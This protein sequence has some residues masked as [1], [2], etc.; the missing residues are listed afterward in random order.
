MWSL[1]KHA[2][3]TYTRTHTHWTYVWAW[4]GTGPWSGGRNIEH[5]LK[6]EAP[7][8]I[9]HPDNV[10]LPAERSICGHKWVRC[11]RQQR[12]PDS[13]KVLHRTKTAQQQHFM[14]NGKYIWPISR[15]VT[16]ESEHRR[17]LAAPSEAGHQSKKRKKEKGW[18]LHRKWVFGEKMQR[19]SWFSPPI[20]HSIFPFWLCSTT[21]CTWMLRVKASW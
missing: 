11:G 15:L 3:A 21:Y 4:L 5:S 9:S 12:E 13:N 6:R 18:F 19:G 8:R 16:Y 2:R 7:R 14:C 10:C 20:S 17:S 1:Q